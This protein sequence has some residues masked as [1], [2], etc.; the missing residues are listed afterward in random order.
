MHLLL[1]L[2]ALQFPDDTPLALHVAVILEQDRTVILVE[3]DQSVATEDLEEAASVEQEDARFPDLN[4]IGV[5][6]SKQN[7]AFFPCRLMLCF[8]IVNTCSE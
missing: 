7:S 6:I 5:F 1:G 2:S 3:R 4:R 8:S